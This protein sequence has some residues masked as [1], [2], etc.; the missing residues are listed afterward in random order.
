MILYIIIIIGLNVI[1]I[2]KIY[3]QHFCFDNSKGY[4]KELKKMNGKQAL[5]TLLIIVILLYVGLY[6]IFSNFMSNNNLHH[7][8]LFILNVIPACSILIGLL[9][10]VL[11]GRATTFKKYSLSALACTITTVALSLVYIFSYSQTQMLDIPGIIIYCIILNF[12]LLIFNSLITVMG[13]K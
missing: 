9:V 10:R 1:Q 6:G 5:I 13:L 12:L 7:Y 8:I 4:L 3:M 11:T 2:N